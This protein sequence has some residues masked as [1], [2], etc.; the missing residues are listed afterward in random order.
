MSFMNFI[1]RNFFIRKAGELEMTAFAMFC[2][3]F[4]PH[5]D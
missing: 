5:D 4:D 3:M 2:E 1:R